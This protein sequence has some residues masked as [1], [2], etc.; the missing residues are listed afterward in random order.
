ME[1][2]R[3][4]GNDSSGCLS[5]LII[6]GLIGLVS[7]CS[8]LKEKLQGYIWTLFRKCVR[9]LLKN[10]ECYDKNTVVFGHDGGFIL[11]WSK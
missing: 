8:N 4:S 3:S 10:E 11:L 2:Y 9:I 5:S 7:L 1:Y 6:I